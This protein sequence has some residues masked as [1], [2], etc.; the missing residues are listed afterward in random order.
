MYDKHFKNNIV[1]LNCW[2]VIKGLTI[3][4]LKTYHVEFVPFVLLFY[5][6][7]FIILPFGSIFST[8][9]VGVFKAEKVN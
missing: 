1:S 6:N 2:N 5:S 4:L 3:L 8:L 9:L 7:V